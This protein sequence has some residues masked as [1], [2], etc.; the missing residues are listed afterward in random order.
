MKALALSLSLL[1]GGGGVIASNPQSSNLPV[2]ITAK[3]HGHKASL[4]YTSKN[5]QVFIEMDTKRGAIDYDFI[6]GGNTY[7]VTALKPQNSW[8]Y[9]FTASYDDGH[10]PKAVAGFSAQDMISGNFAAM[11]NLNVDPNLVNE[12]VQALLGLP[13]STPNF[14]GMKNVGLTLLDPI[15]KLDQQNILGIFY[16]SCYWGCVAGGGSSDRWQTCGASCHDY[17]GSN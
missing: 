11:R 13:T 4:A 3:E 6:S 8:D 12:A 9:L 15:Y 1:L 2:T 10:G 14:I 17:W 16:A 5:M 7:H